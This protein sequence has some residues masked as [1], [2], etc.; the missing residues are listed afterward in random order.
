MN[1]IKYLIESIF[2]GAAFYRT[3]TIKY[4]IYKVYSILQKELQ[5]YGQF[6]LPCYLSTEQAITALWTKSRPTEQLTD[7]LS[8]W[9]SLMIQSFMVIFTPGLYYAL[10]IILN[11][12]IAK[13]TTFDRPSTCW[14]LTVDVDLIDETLQ[15]KRNLCLWTNCAGYSTVIFLRICTLN[16]LPSV[17]NCI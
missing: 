7:L 13:L 10:Y 17:Q 14:W 6:Y 12:W 2:G 15:S 9:C 5:R 4:V 3:T 1:C 16:T 11:K 8:Y